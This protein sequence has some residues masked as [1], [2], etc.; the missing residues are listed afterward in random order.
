MEVALP[1]TKVNDFGLIRL[2]WY[3]N[4]MVFL[5]MSRKE[6]KRCEKKV[7]DGRKALTQV[8]LEKHK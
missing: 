5:R 3:R 4:W 7:S 1:K 8:T 2:P 6:M